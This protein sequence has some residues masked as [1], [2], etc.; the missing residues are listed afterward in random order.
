[1]VGR[2]ELID[3]VGV[4]G[5]AEVFRARP[6]GDPGAAATVVVKR[7]LPHLAED[8]EFR[9]MFMDEARIAA[10]LDHPNVV[11]LID[12]GRA[13]EELYLVLEYVDGAS[14]SRHSPGAGTRR[15]RWW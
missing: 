13:G 10:C 4:G 1:M 5:M 3:R 8:A 15:W 7:I 2:Y 14:L 6:L 11:K 9:A 12:L